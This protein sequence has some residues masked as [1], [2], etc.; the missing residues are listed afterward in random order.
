MKILI[1]L[2]ESKRSL[3]AVDF[4]TARSAL[5]GSDPDVLLFHAQWPMPRDVIR[6]VGH[7]R[8]RTIHDRSAERVFRPALRALAAAEIAPQTIAVVGHPGAEIAKAA[9]KHRVDLIVLASRGL[10]AGRGLL[11][12]SVTTAVLAHGKTPLLVV[13]ELQP[14]PRRQSLLAGVAVD[15]SKYGTA[16][17]RYVL[18]HRALFGARPEIKLIHVVPDF[19]PYAA[20]FAGMALPYPE[21]DIEAMRAG[22]FEAAVEPARSLLREARVDCEAVRL[23]GNAGDQIA[24]FAKSKRL[25]VLVMG[26]HGRG[27]LASALLGSVATRVAAQCRTPLLLIRRA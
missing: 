9:Q 15:G 1:P 5:V 17:V 3:A 6:V 24:A 4:V 11:L 27:A 10:S 21:S 7:G 8:L 18:K 16:A 23:V 2:D 26:S 22:A 25:D 12:G 13:R 14:V 20:D 19:I